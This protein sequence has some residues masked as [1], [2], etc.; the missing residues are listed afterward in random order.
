MAYQR[1]KPARRG[2]LGADAASSGDPKVKILQQ[3]VNRF[4]PSRFTTRV[5]VDGVMGHPLA[6]YAAGVLFDRAK[7]ALD[8]YG[9]GEPAAGFYHKGYNDALA[10]VAAPLPWVAQNLDQVT[11]DVAHYAD[12]LGLPGAEGVISRLVG[13][14]RVWVAAAGVGVLVLGRRKRR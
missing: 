5:V 13:D 3:Q 12:F 4:V 9:P 1:K 10:H 11:Q 2:A 14:W 7:R 6:S 8:T